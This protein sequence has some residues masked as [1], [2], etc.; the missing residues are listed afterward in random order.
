KASPREMVLTSTHDSATTSVMTTPANWTRRSFV[1]TAA[2]A[3]IARL[4]HAAPVRPRKKIALIG[5]VVRK[6]SHAQH[7]LDRHALGYTWGGGWQPPR[8]DLA[9]LYID[10]FP[11]GDLA[12][13]RAKR[14]NLKLSPSIAD[15][16][17]LGTGKL[18]VDGV[19]IIGEHG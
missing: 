8:V 10:Q 7:F 3:G 19:V 14:Y 2:A 4:A 15:A 1:L 17:T 13:S 6:H 11:E 12:R 5:T 9:G 16:L 18:A